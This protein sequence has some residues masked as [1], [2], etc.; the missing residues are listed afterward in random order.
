MRF[1]LIL[2]I[3][4]IFFSCD[5][6]K[7][8]HEKF[9]CGYA[10]EWMAFENEKGSALHP[11]SAVAYDIKLAAC[12]KHDEI[13]WEPRKDITNNF[14]VIRGGYFSKLFCILNQFQ[15]GDSIHVSIPRKDFYSDLMIEQVQENSK[16]K[17]S[18]YL[19][20]KICEVFDKA[21]WKKYSDSI[22]GVEKR[23]TDS[24]AVFHGFFI[25]TSGIISNKPL[26]LNNSVIN[27][28]EYRI[29]Y[30]CRSLDGIL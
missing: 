17:D 10:Y 13:I 19:R 4:T 20:I 22:G 9:V 12:R 30:G 28:R 2:L 5:E 1:V 14:L 21:K 3:F 24:I 8:S 6:Q 25:D 7:L 27:N 18:M 29:L 26:T 23:K 16:R 15:E 11:D